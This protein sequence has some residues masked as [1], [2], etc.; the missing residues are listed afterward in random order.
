MQMARDDFTE[1]SPGERFYRHG[2]RRM[3]GRDIRE[4]HRTASVLELF[5][6]LTFVSA[7]GVAGAQL[8]HGIAEG[9]T[10]SAVIA[11]VIAMLAILWAWVG[12]TWFATSFDNDDWLF[13][14][15]TL[16]QMAGVIV[17]AIGIPDLFASV[18]H[19]DEFDVG[20]MVT[21]YVI[22][23]VGVVALWLRAAYDDPAARSLAT[24]NALTVGLAQ[25]GWVIWVLTPMSFTTAMIWLVII[26]L[27]DLGGPIV[28]E[29]KGRRHGS[30][31]PWH[32][33]HIAERY[34]LLAIIAI[35]ESI[36]GT[37]SAAQMISAAQGWTVESVLAIA[38]GVLISFSLWW[39]YF[40]LPSG[41]VLDV[42]RD[43]V[44]PWT[45]LHLILF[46]A[47]AAVGAGLHVIGYAFDEHY[48]VTTFAAISAIAVPVLGFM[49]VVFI[50]LWW[51]LGT[52][53][54]NPGHVIT[55][56]MPVVAM[57]AAANGAPLWA[58]LLIVLISPLSVIVFYETFEHRGLARGLDRV[59]EGGA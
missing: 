57:V 18:E 38:V 28:A 14:V 2:L 43:K 11:F 5:F 1:L 50:L 8:A 23:R 44:I 46:A 12:Y 42:Q 40:I 15:L 7:F 32:A 47:I 52:P 41:P 34:G 59:I 36:T 13:R 55:F 37:L 17:V 21:G 54:R 29:F 25:I 27:V 58:C 30:G 6:D 39:T 51:L 49:A 31:F 19:H 4:H 24:T 35:G 16:L 33:H 20:V 56:A 26:W 48:H 10:G 9:H 3:T 22:M 53:P 45:Y